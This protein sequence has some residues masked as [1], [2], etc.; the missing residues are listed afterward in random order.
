[1]T[2]LVSGHAIGDDERN[3]AFERGCEAVP[4]SGNADF[5]LISIQA[6]LPLLVCVKICARAIRFA[7]PVRFSCRSRSVV[8]RGAAIT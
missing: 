8:H 4:Y 7:S 1:M 6:T 5:E 3:L 2:I